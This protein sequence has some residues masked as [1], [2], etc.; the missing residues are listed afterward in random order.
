M[1]CSASTGM[2]VPFEEINENTTLASLEKTAPHMRHLEDLAS[3][4]DKL[5]SVEAMI[6]AK[7]SIHLLPLPSSKSFLLSDDASIS[8]YR[9]A[10][11]EMHRLKSTAEQSRAYGDKERLFI[12]PRE[13]AFTAIAQAREDIESYDAASVPAT[14]TMTVPTLRAVV[15]QHTEVL[16]GVDITHGAALANVLRRKRFDRITD[17]LGATLDRRRDAIVGTPEYQGHL[18]V[19]AAV[20]AMADAKEKMSKATA[21]ATLVGK[22]ADLDYVRDAIARMREALHDASFA[23]VED[24]PE[25]EKVQI[26][27]TRLEP[28][29]QAKAAMAELA[30]LTEI[31][32]EMQVEVPEDIVSGQTFTVSIEGLAGE[33]CS[34]LVHWRVAVAMSLISLSACHLLPAHNLSFAKAQ[35]PSKSA[36]MKR[37]RL[38][39]LV[40]ERHGCLRSDRLNSLD[41]LIQKGPVVDAHVEHICDVRG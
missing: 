9:A 6:E 30:S 13:T 39:L 37:K 33:R 17:K 1:G 23:G 35:T 32:R 34:L 31:Y 29:R 26:E 16:D 7:K 3:I 36:C 19:I 40:E 12:E 24:A 28:I 22:G 38:R 15:S 20:E 11:G 5:R 25:A 8:E 21:I 18:A 10:L 4:D 2:V 27:M 14:S 41:L